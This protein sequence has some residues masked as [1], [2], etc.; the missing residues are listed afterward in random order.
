[1]LE[2]GPEIVAASAGGGQAVMEV[3]RVNLTVAEIR[4]EDG[5]DPRETGGDDNTVDDRVIEEGSGAEDEE[6]TGAAT[7]T[8]VDSVD[9]LVPC[10]LLASTQHRPECT[11][12]E[13]KYISFYFQTNHQ[14]IC[15]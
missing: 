5:V 4:A 7:Q 14:S 2:E 6:V 13:N 9:G 11:Q 12:S 1:M 3:H 10:H 8:P 15:R